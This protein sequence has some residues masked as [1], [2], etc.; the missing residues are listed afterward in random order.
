M[1][2]IVVGK[3]VA[4]MAA[5]R[6]HHIKLCIKLLHFLLFEIPVESTAAAL[7]VLC[8]MV[9]HSSLA[10]LLSFLMKFTVCLN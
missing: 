2:G 9:N 6:A 4:E 10:F 7:I 5:L 8:C 3:V 1:S